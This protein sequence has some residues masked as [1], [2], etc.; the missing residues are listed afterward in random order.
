MIDAASRKSGFGRRLYADLEAFAAA[1]GVK[2][3]A[4]EVNSAPPNPISM[5][6]HQSLGFCPVGEL[7][8]RDRS[9]C[10]VLMMKP[11]GGDRA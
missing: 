1:E 8:N 4:C 2:H 9:T 10:V 6:F 5:C 11:V 3:L 7:A